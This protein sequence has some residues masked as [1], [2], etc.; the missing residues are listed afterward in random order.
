MDT[1]IVTREAFSAFKQEELPY[2]ILSL[3]EVV[4]ACTM[5]IWYSIEGVA[6]D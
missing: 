5:L 4:L 2:L 3:F 6:N 1:I